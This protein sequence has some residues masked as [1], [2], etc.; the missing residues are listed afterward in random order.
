MVELQD[1]IAHLRAQVRQLWKAIRDLESSVHRREEQGSDS[2]TASQS[3]G[4][5][6]QGRSSSGYSTSDEAKSPDQFLVVPG[7]TATSAIPSTTPV[8]STASLS[9]LEREEICDQIGQ[10]LARSISGGHRGSSGRDKIPLPSRFWVIVRDYAGQIYSP[11]KVVKS[12]TSC[13][14]LCKPANHE[15]GD[16]VFVGVPS[17]REARRVVQAAQLT[18]PSVIEAW[19]SGSLRGR[20]RGRPTSLTRV[21]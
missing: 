14:L 18:W 2:R 7:T 8:P 6:E 21:Q 13:K 17:E 20:W 19:A 11:V 10:F 4:R 15:C 5:R 12:W 3:I 1:E 16:S 9:W